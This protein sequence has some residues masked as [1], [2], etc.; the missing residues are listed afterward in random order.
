MW[1][2]VRDGIVSGTREGRGCD[3][4]EDVNGHLFDAHSSR[5]SDKQLRIRER[6]IDRDPDTIIILYQDKRRKK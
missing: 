3:C 2:R 1:R 6:G 5:C 4:T